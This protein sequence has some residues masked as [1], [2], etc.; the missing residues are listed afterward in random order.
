MRHTAVVQEWRDPARL[1]LRPVGTGLIFAAVVALWGAYFVPLALRRYDEAGRAASID[2]FSSAMRVVAHRSAAEP[3]EEPVAAA[4]GGTA[5]AVP[6]NEPTAPVD[7]REAAR[8]AARRRRRT[9]ITLVAATVIVGVLAAIAV[10]PVWAVAVPVLLDI[11]WLIACRV[12]VRHERGISRPRRRLGAARASASKNT[13]E[14]EDTVIVTGLLGND[15]PLREHVMERV[16]LDSAELTEDVVDAIPVVTTTGGALWDPVPVTLP[17]Y[18]GKPRAART[19]RTIDFGE[20]DTW[21][22]GHLEGEDT[23]IPARNGAPD[24][25]QRR[26]VGD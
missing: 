19:I 23:V 10:V 13:G 12:Q 5:G 7:T 26:A 21:T 8:T 9:L 4:V 11:A 24:E 16:P 17:T 20:A 3:V 25:L 18:V 15:R 6:T 14:D 2:R 1:P 22:S